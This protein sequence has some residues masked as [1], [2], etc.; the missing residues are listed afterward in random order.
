MKDVPYFK[1]F[2][3][4]FYFKFL[5]HE[6]VPFESAKVWRNLKPIESFKFEPVKTV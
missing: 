1:Y 2:L 6:N 5:E 4:I 3:T